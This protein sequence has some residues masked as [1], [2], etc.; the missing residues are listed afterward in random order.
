M[1][2]LFLA[3][4]VLHAQETPA[5]KQELKKLEGEWRVEKVEAGGVSATPEQ[6]RELKSV[7]FKGNTFTSLAGVARMEG[8]IKID[9]TRKPKTM[10]IMFKSG[11][12]KDKVYQ[13]IYS[14]DGDDLKMCGSEPGKDRPKDFN[15]K[16]KTNLTLM[17]F[18]RAK[19]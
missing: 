6:L 19:S 16:D 13:A 2:L 4:L 14:L 15:I 10:D 1:A 9:P 18:K 11:Q 12:D 17:F 3:G 5:A 8:T 7:T